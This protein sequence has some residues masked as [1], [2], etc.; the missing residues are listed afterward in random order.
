MIVIHSHHHYYNLYYHTYQYHTYV[1]MYVHLQICVYILLLD[2]AIDQIKKENWVRLVLHLLL[3]WCCCFLLCRCNVLFTVHLLT[4]WHVQQTKRQVNCRLN[5]LT[6]LGAVPLTRPTVLYFICFIFSSS[7]GSLY[8]HGPLTLWRKTRKTK[9]NTNANKTKK[10]DVC[11][12]PSFVLIFFY[13]HIVYIL[14]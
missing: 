9:A 5:W 3:M 13:V 11:M 12:L 14:E 2:I 4:N 10:Y 6:I 8:I 7:F 1:C